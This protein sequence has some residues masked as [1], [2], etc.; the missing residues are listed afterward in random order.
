M[1]P[2]AHFEHFKILDGFTSVNLIMGIVWIALVSEIWTHKNNCL[3]KG[4]MVDLTEIFSL[5]QVKVWSWI[6]SKKPLL[7]SDGCLEPLVCMHSI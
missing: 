6:L 3:F 2:R 5:T 1:D 4:G 7:I